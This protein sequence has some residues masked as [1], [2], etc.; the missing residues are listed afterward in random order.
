MKNYDEIKIKIK[1][2]FFLVYSFPETSYVKETFKVKA[3]FFVLCKN[4]KVCC[5]CPQSLLFFVSMFLNFLSKL[6][7]VLL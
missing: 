4:Q 3:C 7:L 1:E 2:K 5:Y 6:R